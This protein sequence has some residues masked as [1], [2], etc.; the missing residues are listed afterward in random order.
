MN[1]YKERLEQAAKVAG[2]KGKY[3]GHHPE[4]GLDYLAIGI[5]YVDEYDCTTCWN[6]YEHNSDA[7]L[8]LIAMVKHQNPNGDGTF[9]IT[10]PLEGDKDPEEIVRRE[11]TNAAALMGESM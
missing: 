4:F 2:I 9:Q 11:I 6:P 5:W 3:G 1:I 7:F 8:L 10:Y